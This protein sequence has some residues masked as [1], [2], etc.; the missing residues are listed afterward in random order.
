M[1]LVAS[2]IGAIPAAAQDRLTQIVL[3]VTIGDDAIRPSSVLRA[4]FIEP[5]G[6]V[7]APVDMNRRA[8][9]RPG[10]DDDANH[11]VTQSDDKR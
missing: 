11:A 10:G 3:S 4:Q 8:F 1:I 5:N 6:A 9:I 7:S 2:M